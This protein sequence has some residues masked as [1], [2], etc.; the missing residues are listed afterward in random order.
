MLHERLEH[1]P[2]GQPPRNAY[3]DLSSGM[4]T[5][6]AALSG[7]VKRNRSGTG[8]YWDVSITDCLVSWLTTSLFAAANGY[9]EPGIPPRREPGF[10]L[11][12]A[13]DGG[14]VTLSIAH[15]D[16]FWRPLC[17][18]LELDEYAA[19]DGNQR[20]GRFEELR[21]RVAARIATRPAQIGRKLL[22]RRGSHPALFW[23]SMRYSRAST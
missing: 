15:E 5:V 10:G 14:I 12:R 6:I 18:V 9:R 21:D 23:A 19:L 7:L 17:E 8:S 13:S 20:A 16:W 22:T 2:L 4:F 3:A 1:G 11:Y